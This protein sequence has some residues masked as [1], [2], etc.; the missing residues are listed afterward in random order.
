MSILTEK[1]IP[2][3]IIDPQPDTSNVLFRNEWNKCFDTFYLKALRTVLLLNITVFIVE[4]KF[5]IFLIILSLI[6]D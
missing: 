1:K 2:S 5:E 4:R 6:F 3:I